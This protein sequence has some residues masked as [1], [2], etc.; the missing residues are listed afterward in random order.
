[1]VPHYLNTVQNLDYVGPI[2]EVSYYRTNEMSEG[3]RREFHAWYD[4]QKSAVFENRRNLESYCQND[5]RV[6]SKRVEYIGVSLC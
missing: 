5:F 1:M 2:P 6:L 4:N 3:D